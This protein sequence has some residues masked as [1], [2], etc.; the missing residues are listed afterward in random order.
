[1]II[2]WPSW[3]MWLFVVWMVA[4][5]VWIVYK[6]RKRNTQVFELLIQQMKTVPMISMLQAKIGVLR[7]SLAMKDAPFKKSGGKTVGVNKAP[8][9]PEHVDAIK[10]MGGKI[11]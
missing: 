7:V 3:V 4:Q 11:L 6:F 2:A 5:I 1:M 8:L 10:K 9:S